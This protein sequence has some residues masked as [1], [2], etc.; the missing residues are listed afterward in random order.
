MLI[1]YDQEQEGVTYATTNI[2]E[3][4]LSRGTRKLGSNSKQ[5]RLLQRK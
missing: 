1:T 4:G 5:R 3:T 2:E